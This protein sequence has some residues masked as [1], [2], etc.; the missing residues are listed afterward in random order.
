MN[1]RNDPYDL[2]G[3]KYFRHRNSQCKSLITRMCFGIEGS[4]GRKIS[5][6]ESA[7]R[8]GW[9]WDKE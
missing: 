6:R 3:K 2:L 9:C 7:W 8:W 4:T 1:G 5:Q